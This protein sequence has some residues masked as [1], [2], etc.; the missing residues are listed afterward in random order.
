MKK[1]VLR[2]IKTLLFYFILFCIFITFTPYFHPNV[3]PTYLHTHLC[4]LYMLGSSQGLDDGIN[5]NLLK[6]SIH[7]SST[8]CSKKL[9]W[10]LYSYIIYSR[11]E[12][13]F[14]STISCICYF[15]EKLVI[16][17]LLMENSREV[18]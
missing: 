4:T 12:G 3:V 2:Q 9:F 17:K 16:P 11:R 5:N 8:F 7:M 10:S 1:C 18:E 6:L 14:S 13:V 15:N